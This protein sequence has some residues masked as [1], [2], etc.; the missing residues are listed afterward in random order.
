MYRRVEEYVVVVG[1]VLGAQIEGNRYSRDLGFRF[2]SGILLLRLVLPRGMELVKEL[3]PQKEPSPQ[4]V[5][6]EEQEETVPVF[7]Q[8]QSLTPPPSLCPLVPLRLSRDCLP[9]RLLGRDPLPLTFLGGR[10]STYPVG[11]RKGRRPFPTSV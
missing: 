8:C 7:L 4:L 1:K 6:R 5:A 2:R 3:E 9:L 11:G 10:P